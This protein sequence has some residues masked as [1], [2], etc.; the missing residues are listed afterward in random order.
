MTPTDAPPPHDRGADESP[1]DRPSAPKRVM[2]VEDE[3]LIALDLDR[4][5]AR[6]GY[7]VVGIADNHDDAV[8][9]FAQTR[10]DIVLMDIFI[11]GDADG[12]QTA[13][14]VQGIADV[15]VVFLTAY[16]DDDTTERASTVSPYGYLL[17]PFDERSL[18]VTM[19]VALQRHA[20]DSRLRILEAAVSS[21]DI[22]ILL[23]RVDGSERKIE[24]ANS[25]FIEL[26][27]YP[28]EMILGQRPCFLAHDPEGHQAQRLQQALE[29]LSAASETLRVHR[30]SGELFWSSV[31]LSPVRDRTGSTSHML[32]FHADVSREREAQA[33]LA[34][35]QRLE[36][37]GRLAAGVAHDFNNVLGSIVLLA[38]LAKEQTE[39]EH[40]R[41]DLDEMLGAAN[42]GSLLTRKLLN[43]CRSD[44][45]ESGD[46]AELI[47]TIEESRGLI[48]QLTGADVDLVLRLAS[49]PINVALD[50]VSIEQ[51]LLNLAINA[52]DA[53]PDGGTLTITIE[54]SLPTA[55]DQASQGVATIEVADTGSGID[56]ELGEQVFEPFFTTKPKGL[57][58]GL[59]LF[60]CRTL[61]ENVGGT[62]GV[63]SES[64][65][66][67]RFTI[68]VPLTSNASD[69]LPTELPEGVVGTASGATCLLVDDDPAVRRAAARALAKAGFEVV[70]ASTGEAA[71]R[72]LDERG[73]KLELVICDI[74][75]PGISGNE[76]LAH[77][78]RSAPEAHLLAITGFADHSVNDESPRAPTLW[79]PFNASTLVRRALDLIG[80][81]T[82]G[83]E[84]QPEAEVEAPPA[85]A[86][87]AGEPEPVPLGS[88]SGNRVL[89][90]DDDEALARSITQALTGH[91]LTVLS[92]SSASAGLAAL[93]AQPFDAAIVDINLP[94]ADGV[95]LL[96]EIK[97]RDSLLST[98]VITGTPTFREAQR[99]LQ[100]RANGFLTKPITHRALIDEVERALGDT[101]LARLQH[102]LLMAKSASSALMLDVAQ[103]RRDFHASLEG[104]FVVF[105]PL[106]RP[107]DS[108]IFAFEALMRSS[109]PYANPLD[110]IAAAEALGRVA[111]MGRV[112]RS[113]IAEALAAHPH[114]FEAIF[115]NLH[116]TELRPD[117]LLREDE[118]LLPYAGR[119]VLEVTERVQLSSLEDVL[120]T[121]KVLREV[122]Y[123][124]A[125]DDIGDGYAGLSSLVM[126][127]PDVAKIDMSLV[128][129]VDRSSVK[130][131]LIGSLV[132]VCRRNRAQTVAEGVE[133]A[134]E[135]M[136]LADLGVDLLQGYYFS[137]PAPAFPTLQDPAVTEGTPEAR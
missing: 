31:S 77:A 120:R 55:D 105:Q 111:E 98:L 129:G 119:V 88:D 108:S 36:I 94:D 76:V 85:A 123:R 2:I 116:P 132:G 19:R 59:G 52:A 74:V 131:E 8:R 39:D 70:E 66:G 100:G 30:A 91:G 95:E 122:G 42:R 96:T 102:R 121:T 118:P 62:I 90:I 1:N 73:D 46:G 133:T 99:A 18:A 107:H 49:G 11:Q 6:L 81:S 130:R 125:L 25:A 67:T 71:C 32:V 104:L 64:G 4:R 50:S 47:S 97:Q 41:A 93:E 28:R 75:L 84:D 15:P 87:A 113:K 89:V 86:A 128:R 7:D 35:S 127:G 26:S 61:V 57:G 124:I 33:A 20:S 37:V 54:R 27:G 115:V 45:D 40:M 5:L 9:L 56:A 29:Q 43:F 44:P 110:M 22:G 24:F 58:T 106:V 63:R 69:L 38:D 68:T 78:R 14:D 12:I 21:A 53:M 80:R 16:A 114:R 103:T 92:A 137:R 101:Q 48:E 134:E 3:A 82:Y 72:T 34:E 10:P 109:G 17:K 83:A 51:I 126:L 136:V 117:L 112:V 65:K 60:M 135:A 79:K 13:A 23:V